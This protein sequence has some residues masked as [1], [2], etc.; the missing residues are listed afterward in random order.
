M[1]LEREQKVSGKHIATQAQTRLVRLQRNLQSRRLFLAVFHEPDLG[2]D[3]DGP[4]A[5]D[6][7]NKLVR[8]S[9]WLDLNDRSVVM[10]MTNG[11]GTHLTNEKKRTHLIDLQR[12]Q[13]IDQAHY[14]EQRGRH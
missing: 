9:C 14:Q 1:N 7:E 10:V 11:I 12:D 3:P 6:A 5:R 8:R 4:F 13:L 2:A